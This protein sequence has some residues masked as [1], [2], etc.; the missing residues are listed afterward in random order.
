MHHFD[1][2]QL[3][4]VVFFKLYQLK[5]RHLKSLSTITDRQTER[6][7]VSTIFPN[8]NIDLAQIGHRT[9]HYKIFF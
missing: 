4:V 3:F 7:E 5:L 2:K 8:P 1:S 9:K 6:Q